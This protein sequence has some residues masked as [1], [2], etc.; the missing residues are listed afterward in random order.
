MQLD[1]INADTIATPLES[2]PDQA[3]LVRDLN[4]R[5]RTLP[6]LHAR[7]SEAGGFTWLSHDEHD[8]S[9][10]AFMRHACL[11]LAHLV[12]REAGY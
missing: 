12:R 6:A 7:D 4:Q 9:V 1:P 11:P 2:H 5:Y 3:S 8:L 10:L